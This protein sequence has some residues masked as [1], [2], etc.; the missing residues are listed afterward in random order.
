MSVSARP[1]SFWKTIRN[2]YVTLENTKTNMPLR[3]LEED[4]R[5]ETSSR[6][7]AGPLDALEAN[8]RRGSDCWG[9]D[10]MVAGGVMSTVLAI[11]RRKRGIAKEDHDVSRAKGA[12]WC[13]NK[14]N[15][16]SECVCRCYQSDKSNGVDPLG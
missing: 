11:H 3:L 2:N 15:P 13:E 4:F 10:D 6:L 12:P 5:L 7:A 14:L 8:G 1:I 16:L 9:S